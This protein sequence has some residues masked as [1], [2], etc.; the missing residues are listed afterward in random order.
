MKDV[1]ELSFVK[2]DIGVKEPVEEH[3]IFLPT[4]IGLS[5][6][7]PILAKKLMGYQSF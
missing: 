4:V 1:R 2:L 3:Q 5:D 7:S 6:F